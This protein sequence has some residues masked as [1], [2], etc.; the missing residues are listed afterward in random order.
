MQVAVWGCGY[1][2]ATHA[3]AMAELGDGRVRVVGIEPDPVKLAALRAGRVPFHEPDLP[4][5]LEQHCASGRLVFTD[6]VAAA[7][8]ADVHF[9]CVGTPQLPW[10]DA[11]DLRYV[12]AAVR[13]ICSLLK[14]GAVVVGKSTVPVGTAGRLAPQVAA[15]GGTLVWNPEFLREGTAVA[16]SLRPD[17]LVIGAAD[18][19]DAA[20]DT[21]C[22]L[23]AEPLTSGTALVRCDLPTA[24]LAKISANTFLALKISYVNALAELCDAT[25]ADVVTLAD[26]LGH[27]ARIGRRFLN[28]GLGFGGGCLPKDI[29]AFG[30]RAG[31]L[32]VADAVALVEAADRINDRA[33]DRAVA[34]TVELLGDAGIDTVDAVVVVLGAAFKPDSDDV[35]DSPA[36][37][38]ATRLAAKGAT[39]RVVDPVVTDS[40]SFVVDADWRGA[41]ADADA[42]VLATEWDEYRHLDPVAVGGLMRHRLVVDARNALAP[43]VW[44]AAGFAYRGLGRR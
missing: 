23:Y 42:V 16:D 20:I 17:R 13:S 40:A 33:R 43:A 14:P 25:G 10:S 28:A 26:A 34:A 35:R 44:K 27:D 37:A 3:A 36:L 21:V 30:A 31:E 5:L 38:V 39:V 6:D 19:A 18:P 32:G 29:R 41:V 12:D 11:C 1:L 4:R 2:G 15:A 24:E 7:A 9:V 22:A 8:D